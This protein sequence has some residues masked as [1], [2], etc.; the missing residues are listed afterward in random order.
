[1]DGL[2]YYENNLKKRQRSHQGF[3]AMWFNDKVDKEN[4][5]PDMSNVYTKAIKP[6]IENEDQ[7]NAVRI[8]CIEYCD[9]INDE[10]IAQNK[11]K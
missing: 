4:Y 8:D 3:V 10:M 11:K 2:R 1:M 7:L 9:D 5:K 6:A